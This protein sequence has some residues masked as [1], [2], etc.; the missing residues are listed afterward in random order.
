MSSD[1]DPVEKPHRRANDLG[2]AEWTRCSISVWSDLRKTPEE[3]R[4]KHPASFPAA[5]AERAI[6]SFV[7]GRGKNILDPFA[8]TGSTLAAAFELGHHGIGF[9]IAGEYR[10]QATE[11]LRAIG[12]EPGRDYTLHA[13]PAQEAAR[14]APDGGYDFVFTSPPYWNIMAQKRTA[15][16]REVRDYAANGRSPQDLARL[17][18]YE[19]YLQA[20]GG[21]FGG[22]AA[23]MNPGAYC[24]VN[25]MDLRKKDRF[26]PLHSDLARVLQEERFGGFIFDDLIIWDRRA[27][28][29][30]LRPLGYPAVFRINKVH[31]YL[32]ILRKRPLPTRRGAR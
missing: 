20:L 7:Q 10:T 27:D 21:I 4:L 32:V 26:F 5:L 24:V 9:E 31:E 28:Y 15:D 19:E 22:I 6:R 3:R 30:S 12:A 17:P 23:R 16:M 11:R 29:N 25:V 2:G 1:T 13:E 14:L 8:G 18:D